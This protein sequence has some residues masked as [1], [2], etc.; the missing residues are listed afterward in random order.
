MTKSADAQRK[1]K[2]SS[3]YPLNNKGARLYAIVQFDGGCRASIGLA[4]AGA[5]LQCSDGHTEQVGVLLSRST[6]N[7]A[8]YAGLLAGIEL[9]LKLK[10]SEIHIS[11]DSMLVVNQVNGHWQC[12]DDRMRK[13]CKQARSLLRKFDSWTLGWVP[14]EENVAADKVCN[15]VMDKAVA[16]GLVDH[17]AATEYRNAMQRASSSRI[18]DMNSRGPDAPFKEWYELKVPNG[19]DEFSSK[20]LPALLKA[21]P[22]DIQDEI[23]RI[24]AERCRIDGD[25]YTEMSDQDRAKCLRWYLRGLSPDCAVRKIRVDNEVSMMAAAY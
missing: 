15:Y 7:E 21:V 11:G 9:A 3:S 5:V 8:E 24:W 17:K 23:D 6:N 1:F 10:V 13:L 14:R 18:A 16:D 19:R 12:K 22:Q 20:R 2:A 25:L 4:S